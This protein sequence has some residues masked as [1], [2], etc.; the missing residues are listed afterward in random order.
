MGSERSTRLPHV[1]HKTRPCAN[2]P[3]HEMHPGLCS[4]SVWGVG[5]DTLTMR[6]QQCGALRPSWSWVLTII[7]IEQLIDIRLR[8]FSKGE[9]PTF[10]SANQI[11]L[12]SCKLR[13]DLWWELDIFLGHSCLRTWK[14]IK[15]IPWLCEILTFSSSA[16]VPCL[17]SV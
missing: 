8:F 17:I 1:S 11:T 7:W 9:M 15:H 2:T 3:K 5:S 6:R 10:I 12:V 4:Q 14:V 16:E 13:H